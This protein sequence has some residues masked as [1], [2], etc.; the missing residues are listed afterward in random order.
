MCGGRIALLDERRVEYAVYCQVCVWQAGPFL[1]KDLA[2]RWADQH[3]E[4]SPGHTVEVRPL[5]RITQLS[6]NGP[7]NMEP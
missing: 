7:R 6:P 1:S 3:A 4:R 2:Q 5:A